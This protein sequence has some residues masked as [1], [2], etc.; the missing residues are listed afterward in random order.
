[1]S[2]DWNR[3]DKNLIV[4]IALELNLPDILSFCR[5]NKRFN[6]VV[7][8]SDIFWSKKL[9]NDFG[10]NAYKRHQSDPK[11]KY[12]RIHN[13]IEN[14]LERS[15]FQRAGPILRTFV[16]KKT[17]RDKFVVDF[18]RFLDSFSREDVRRFN[19]LYLEEGEVEYEFDSILDSVDKLDDFFKIFEPYMVYREEDNWGDQYFYIFS[20]IYPVIR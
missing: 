20:L 5:S 3:L 13:D 8:E 11:G 19:R 17:I 9:V 16:N 1:M 2:H 4:Q 6:E 7:C 14:W 18:K 10:V 15:I 12:R